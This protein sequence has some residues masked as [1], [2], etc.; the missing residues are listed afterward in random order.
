MWLM[1]IAGLHVLSATFTLVAIKDS[2]WV[3]QG[4]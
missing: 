3:Y 1:F 4:S 2:S